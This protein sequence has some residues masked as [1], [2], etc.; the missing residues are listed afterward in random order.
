MV[1][2][3]PKRFISSGANNGLLNAEHGAQDNSGEGV[4]AMQEAVADV[5]ATSLN[6]DSDE[7]LLEHSGITDED[8]TLAYLQ[9][10]TSANPQHSAKTKN[11]NSLASLAAELIDDFD[12]PFEDSFSEGL[13]EDEG[14]MRPSVRRSKGAKDSDQQ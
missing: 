5:V 10:T 4:K 14:Q 12:D 6:A 11:N 7:E 1:F 9:A 3:T 13:S 8:A 2:A